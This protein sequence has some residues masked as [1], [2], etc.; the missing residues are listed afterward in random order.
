[1]GKQNGTITGTWEA[2]SGGVAVFA[3]SRIQFQG[4]DT[5][6]GKSFTATYTGGSLGVSASPVSGSG[7]KFT[8]NGS[9]NQFAGWSA[10][11]SATAGVH[12]SYSITPSGYSLVMYGA[13]TNVGVTLLGVGYTTIGA[14][15]PANPLSPVTV[16]FYNPATSTI[17][18]QT[19]SIIGTHWVDGQKVDILHSNFSVRTLAGKHVSHSQTN[20]DVINGP[21]TLDQFR[22]LPQ[23]HITAS[24]AL[25]DPHIYHDSIMYA[26]ANT[27]QAKAQAA[28]ATGIYPD[29]IL[30]GAA[31]HGG[32][33]GGS[34]SPSSAPSSTPGSCT[35]PGL[36]SP[37]LPGANVSSTP[38]GQYHST[39]H[40][41]SIGSGGMVTGLPVVLDLNGNG[42]EISLSTKAAFDYDGNGFRQPTAWVAPS[43]GFLVIDLNADG[44][45]GAGDGKIDQAKEL[46]LSMWGPA[47][48]TDL[49]AVDGNNAGLPMAA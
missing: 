33:G 15:A 48:S 16:Q 43:D 24:Q 14:S 21:Q 11:V 46:V 3:G 28:L 40:Y 29:A 34:A 35:G 1:M 41:A 20:V 10:G 19:V 31:G 6:T 37:S 2:V 39:S 30:R 23:M 25:Q 42:V 27:P 44:T 38:S 32:G 47:G 7:G 12:A 18:T 13:E 45:R 8:F 36:T 26:A 17:E 4:Y 9:L 49:Q 5:T 22:A